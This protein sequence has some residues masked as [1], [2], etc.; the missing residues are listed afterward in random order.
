MIPIHPHLTSMPLFKQVLHS[1]VCSLLLDHADSEELEIR[2]RNY[3]C[4]GLKTTK[5]SAN[6]LSDSVDYWAGL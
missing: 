3:H 5:Q 6:E 2:R 1:Q 4:L